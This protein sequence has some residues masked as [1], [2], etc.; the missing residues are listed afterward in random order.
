MQ[1]FKADLH[2][3]T[4]LSPC[5]SLEMSPGRI[6]EKAVK[7]GIDLLG[8]TDHNSTLMCRVIAEVAAEQNIS[9]LP[10]AEINTKEEVHCLTF[11]QDWKKLET[12]QQYLDQ[13]LIHIPNDPNRFGYQVVVD[14]NEQILQE[15]DSLLIASLDQSLDDVAE[16]VHSLGGIFIP[17]HVDRPTNSITSQLGFIPEN[18][19]ADALEI[20]KFTTLNEIKKLQPNV[21]AFSIIQSSDAH[22]IDN[23]GDISCCFHMESP[24]FEEVKMALACKNGRKV[25]LL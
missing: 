15:V 23:I 8:I 7:E 12:F 25:T 11:F 1:S 17:A 22:F 2:T 3:H 9:I 5:G 14:R 24:D 4:V 13:H 10:G 18:L 20:S 19:K 21:D 6:I 16:V